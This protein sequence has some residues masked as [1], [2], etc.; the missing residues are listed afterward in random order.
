MVFGGYG[1]DD[2][3]DTFHDVQPFGS[4]TEAP[5]PK[6]T[7]GPIRY[8]LVP[9]ATTN[10]VYGIV[11]TV[12]TSL[13]LSFSLVHAESRN[14]RRSVSFASLEIVGSV[15]L[16]LRANAVTKTTFVHRTRLGGIRSS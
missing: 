16:R 6:R 1:K 15:G 2:R 7:G 9:V 14:F 13:A 3:R 5:S 10:R 4:R 11:R 8:V 12:V